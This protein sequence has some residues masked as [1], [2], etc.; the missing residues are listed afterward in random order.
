MKKIIKLI[1]AI[2]VIL[3][4]IFIFYNYTSPAKETL[5]ASYTPDTIN[6]IM[7][8]PPSS[9]QPKGQQIGQT[10]I[11]T[12]GTA[13]VTKVIFKL[14]LNPYNLATS[15][16]IY[17]DLYA[18]N[19]TGYPTGAVLETSAPESVTS[20]TT[21]LSDVSFIFTGDVTIPTNSVAVLRGDFLPSGSQVKVNVM[22]TGGGYGGVVFIHTT[23][24]Q[25]YSVFDA[26]FQVY[27]IPTP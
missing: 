25:L 13:R 10:F 4:L 20:L 19:S 7:V 8:Q 11:L 22:N 1:L 9:I 26:Y 15:G 24:W 3:A 27:G 5:L 14:A 2:G 6:V 23:G 16:D 12:G 21:T 17:C 18:L